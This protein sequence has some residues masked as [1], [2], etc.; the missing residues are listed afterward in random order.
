MNKI[1]LLL[2]ISLSLFA[3]DYTAK[4]YEKVLSSIFEDLPIVVY[5]DRESVKELQKS[6][7]FEIQT[8][9][10]DNVDV[11]VGSRFKDLPTECRNKPL[12][13][14]TYKAYIQNG[15]AFGAFYWR[16]GRPQIHF[17]KTVLQKFGLELPKRLRRF[18]DE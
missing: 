18:V 3:R 10:S 16:K 13:A 6:D 1:F 7:I 9:C 11:L 14:T 2:L 8:R 17:N 4:L 5:A 12:F 15:N